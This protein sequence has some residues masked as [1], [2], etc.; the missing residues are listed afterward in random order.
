MFSEE[1]S[2]NCETVSNILKCISNPVRL[3]ILCLLTEKKCS[4]GELENRLKISQSMVSQ[5]VLALW[6]A[7]I[8]D[9]EKQ[10]QSVYYGVA[11]TRVLALMTQLY[12]LFCKGEQQ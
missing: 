11:D 3:K 12:D 1:M 5:H 10:G 6:R 8:L 2:K 4:V 7:G 9:R